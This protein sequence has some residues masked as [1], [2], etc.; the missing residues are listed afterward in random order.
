MSEETPHPGV[1]PQ[2]APRC[3]ACPAAAAQ[4]MGIPRPTPRRPLSCAASRPPRGWSAAATTNSSLA[5][6]RNEHALRSAVARLGWV[7]DH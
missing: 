1:G 4:G 6:R 3:R 7:L 2:P 5:V